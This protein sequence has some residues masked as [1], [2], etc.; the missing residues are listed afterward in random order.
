[1][2]PSAAGRRLCQTRA[3]EPDSDIATYTAQADAANL[4]GDSVAVASAQAPWLGQGHA[5][6]QEQ[7]EA[8]ALSSASAAGDGALQLPCSRRRPGTELCHWRMLASA[9]AT[10]PSGAGTSQDEAL[11][12]AVWHSR[13]ARQNKRAACASNL[14][15]TRPAPAERGK[16]SRSA[17][18]AQPMLRAKMRCKLSLFCA[19]THRRGCSLLTMAVLGCLLTMAVLGCL[20]TTVQQ[21][22]H[23]KHQKMPAQKSQQGPSRDTHLQRFH[24]QRCCSDSKRRS[25][26]P[27]PAV[28]HCPSPTA[29]CRA[30]WWS[31][32]SAQSA[33]QQAL[34]TP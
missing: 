30:S 15:A 1:M 25:K 17:E 27:Q 14:R 18:S 4:D 24:Q 2:R 22:N 21:N 20:L 28:P 12:G 32:C 29:P 3:T 23:H 13:S 6:V 8:V 33:G 34:H 10:S 16:C 11:P 7:V 5:E 26:P 19:G 9:P 31:P